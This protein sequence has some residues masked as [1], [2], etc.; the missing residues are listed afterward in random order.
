MHDLIGEAAERLLPRPIARVLHGRVAAWL[1]PRNASAA[2]LAHHLLCSGDEAAAVPHLAAAARQ[3]WHLGRSRESRDAYLQAA[4]IEAGRGRATAAFDLLYECAEAI[5]TLGP[6]EAFDGVVERMAAFAGDPSRQARLMYMQ[7]HCLYQRGD[8]EGF[9]ARMDDVLARAVD[10]GDRLVQAECRYAKGNDALQSGRLHEAI[11]HIRAAAALHRDEGRE[12][13]A[14]VIEGS[15]RTAALWTGQA[16]LMLAE[17][18]AAMPRILEVGSS[19]ARVSVQ[20]RQAHAELLLGDGD[21]ASLS[22]RRAIEALRGTDMNGADFASSTR[23][24]ADVMRRRGHWGEA[25]AV[26]AEAEQRLPEQGDPDRWLAQTLAEVC[27]DLGRPDLAHRHIESFAGASG[28]PA[29]LRQRTV[30]LRWAYSLATGAPIDAA[31]AIADAVAS[32]HL[33]QA[34]KLMLVGGQGGPSQASP[35]ACAD[36]IGRCA[37]EGLR[38]QLAPLHSLHAWLLATEGNV[39]A[40][41]AEIELAQQALLRGDPGAMTPLC[42]LWLAR[43]CRSLDL[44]A[45]AARHARHAVAWLNERVQRDVPAEFRDSFLHRH[46]VHRELRQVVGEAP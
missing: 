8:H 33:L 38:E 11:G 29:R 6:R 41:Q 17:D 46:P 39:A 42:G 2:R 43:A 24:I 3:A 15:A 45:E 18:R 37:P 12:Q 5:A 27:L 35:R 31:K 30:A 14:I 40:A 22:A 32:E 1:A 23:S 44:P 36:L 21:T 20:V 4:A 34:C 7:V 25:L 13:R 28:H 26:V 9:F 19:N 16:R 10:V